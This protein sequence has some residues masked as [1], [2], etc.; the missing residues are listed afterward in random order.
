MNLENFN[1]GDFMK[2]VLI[3]LSG[4]AVLLTLFLNVNSVDAASYGCRRTSSSSRADRICL[5]SVTASTKT[6]RK[7][8]TYYFKYG[9]SLTGSKAYSRSTTYSAS[10]SIGASAWGVATIEA[11]VGVQSTRTETFSVSSSWT[12]PSGRYAYIQSVFKRK[13]VYTKRYTYDG[14]YRYGTYRYPAYFSYTE[15]HTFR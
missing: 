1:K 8:G 3:L 15:V 14:A 5:Y 6:Y 9:G 4:V 11:T 10:L 12:I 13:K 2:K 7:S